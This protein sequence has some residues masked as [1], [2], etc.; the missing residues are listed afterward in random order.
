MKISPSTDHNRTLVITDIEHC[1]DLPHDLTITVSYRAT[2]EDP[3]TI[4]KAVLLDKY[5]IPAII[6]AVNDQPPERLTTARLLVSHA[7]LMNR[8]YPHFDRADAFV[9]RHNYD[10]EFVELAAV[11]KKLKIAMEGF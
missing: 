11:A 2:D 1:G 10:A 8:D 6:K 5:V 4:D 7:V 3:Y 9:E